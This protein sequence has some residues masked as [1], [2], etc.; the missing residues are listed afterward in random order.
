MARRLGDQ[1]LTQAERLQVR[2]LHAAGMPIEAIPAA[3]GRDLRTV[4]RVLAATGG[5]PPPDRQPIGPPAL[6][7]G[8]R[9]DQSRTAGG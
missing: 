2:V 1:N 3:I 6:D 5:I 7:R 4:Q 9:G 8:A